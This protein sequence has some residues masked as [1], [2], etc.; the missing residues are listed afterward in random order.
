MNSRGTLPRST[1]Q[2]RKVCSRRQIDAASGMTWNRV[3]SRGIKVEARP[4][5]DD[6]YA[7]DFHDEVEM[8]GADFI[9]RTPFFKVTPSVMRLSRLKSG[10]HLS[11]RNQNESV[12]DK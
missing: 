2:A 3:W 8:P 9:L 6:G 11:Q 10:F 5:E 7:C 4:Q 1:T 12:M